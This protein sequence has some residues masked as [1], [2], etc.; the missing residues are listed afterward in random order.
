MK[1]LNKEIEFSFTNADNMEKL[2]NSIEIAQN[3]MNKINQNEKMSVIIN[4]TYEI[5]SECLNGIFGNG[6]SEEIFEGKKE[7][8]S[9][10][11][12]FNDI[13]K[14]KNEQ[15]KELEEEINNLQE[16]LNIAENKYSSNRATRRANK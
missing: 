13:V 1:I 9:C 15:E 4:N 5:V 16:N 8:K 2:E 6:F 11:K 7:F 3:K 12:A 10:I 14:A